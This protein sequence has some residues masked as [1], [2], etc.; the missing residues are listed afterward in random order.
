MALSIWEKLVRI[1]SKPGTPE[2]VAELARHRF[3]QYL[4]RT[5][6]PAASA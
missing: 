5:L 1:I 4:A 6:Q 2:T 3:F